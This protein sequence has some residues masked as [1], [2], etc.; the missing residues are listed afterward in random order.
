MA[1]EIIFKVNDSITLNRQQLGSAN[2]K[3]REGYDRFAAEFAQK[4]G[5]KSITPDQFRPLDPLR[6][7]PA[8]LALLSRL[9]GL[10]GVAP[11]HL[12]DNVQPDGP[13]LLLDTVMNP[14]TDSFRRFGYAKPGPPVAAEKAPVFP[15]LYNYFTIP[16]PDSVNADLL[17]PFLTALTAFLP[18]NGVKSFRIPV[19]N[20]VSSLLDYA[21]IK[22]DTTAPGGFATP[23]AAS[24]NNLNQHYFHTM[25]I[26]QSTPANLGSNVGITVIEETSWY[27]N[28]PQFNGAAFSVIAP[29]V[30]PAP[31]NF[32]L[33]A[34]GKY[35]SFAEHGT[36]VL[37]ILRAKLADS[38]NTAGSDLCQ[39][40]VP[41]ATVR[42]ASSLSELTFKAPPNDLTVSH[43]KYDEAGALLQTLITTRLQRGDVILLELS[44]NSQKYPIDFAPAMFDLIRLADHLEMTV[45]AAAG[46]A[47]LYIPD[48]TLAAD[49]LKK[50]Q[51]E[52]LSLVTGVNN[53]KKRPADDS[54]WAAYLRLQ[55]QIAALYAT[56]GEAFTAFPTPAEFVAS[57]LAGSSPAIL[58]G[59]AQDDLSGGIAKRLSTSSWGPR[60]KV[61]AQGENILT[62]FC[63]DQ[64]TPNQY[65]AFTS[66][67]GASAII[68]GFVAS[69]Q[70]LAKSRNFLLQPAQI[71][72]LLALG[73]PVFAQI[74][75]AGGF[76]KATGGVIP[77]YVQAVATLN[78]WI[79]A[80]H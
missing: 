38:D 20:P 76:D 8:L 68:A 11:R 65:A 16:L 67:S 62:T 30:P 15:N 63:G 31:P 52:I 70:S 41:E 3:L 54:V 60:V 66:T 6:S 74:S 14:P 48:P 22:D 50:F 72:Q 18:Q 61:Y 53:P 51:K 40:I 4:A 78:G 13:L 64:A 57:V 19:D 29:L 34:P 49:Q 69:L 28:H 23:S 26:D 1:R 24:A 46:N 44:L 2:I 71:R 27:V 35:S 10:L 77:D 47:S 37:G 5:F 21:Y 45:V 33:T 73:N 9:T 25:H 79:V 56:A 59:A 42:L 39:G 75:A 12:F 58:V 17:A 55:A 80:H 43:K 7:W 36:S 32:T